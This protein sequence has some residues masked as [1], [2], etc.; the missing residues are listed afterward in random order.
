MVTVSGWRDVEEV[1]AGAGAEGAFWLWGALDSGAV[2]P[3][4]DK[5][6]DHLYIRYRPAP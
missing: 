5:L 2:G 6:M 3:I 4:T 1:C